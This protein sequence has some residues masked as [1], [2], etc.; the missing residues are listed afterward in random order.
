[1]PHLFTC[2]HCDA[3][4]QVEDRYSGHSGECFNCGATIQLPHF[5]DTSPSYGGA[6]GKR[7]KQPLGVFVA[8]GIVLILLVCLGFAA[9]RFGGS[10][11]RRLGQVRLRNA[12]ISNLES[13]AAALNAYAADHGTYPPSVL[14]DSAG[15]PLHSWRVLILPYLNEQELYDQFD[16]SQPWNAEINL[17]ASYAMPSAYEH[18]ATATGFQNQ[19]GYV[20]LT[21]PQTLFPNGKPG[22]PDTIADDPAQTILVIGG[23]PAVSVNI[24]S[25]AEPID[26]PF[27]AMQ[28]MIN[29]T[30]GVEPGG[31]L[32]DGVT[33][34]TVD[35][36][37][38]F[39]SEE[40]SPDTFRALV[41]P[42]GGELLPDSTLD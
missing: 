35:G 22:S 40:M 30:V 7:A 14:R 20:L 37:G 9:L 32:E 8:A 3:K 18:P 5:A 41:T 26:L 27:S 10:S 16:L 19:P 28:G 29:G 12:S 42:S 13:I 21:G 39:V 31:W 36:R 24:G 34:A 25:W 23:K 11:V 2:P 15:K 6:G 4:T 38:H 17:Q 33:M 1:M